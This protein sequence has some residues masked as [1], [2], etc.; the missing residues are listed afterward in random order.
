M[1]LPSESTAPLDGTTSGWVR[2]VPPRLAVFSIA[3]AALLACFHRPLLDLARFSFGH[4]LYSYILLIPPV[5]LYLMW[6]VRKERRMGGAPAARL[7]LLPL[8]LGL[9]LLVV[10]WAG[11]RAGRQFE[12]TD[13]LAV[14]T[15]S[16]WSFIAASCCIFLGA[17]T[18]RAIA[19]PL[20]FLLFASPLPASAYRAFESFLQHAS[21]TTAY[22]FFWAAFT[23]VWQDGLLLHLPGIGVEVAPECSGIRSTLVL[24]ITS[25]LAAHLFLRGPWRRAVLIC[26]VL[27]LALLRNGFRIF[28]IGE[29]CVHVGPQMINSPIHRHGGPL[30]FG[31]SLIPFL[32][33]LRRLRRSEVS[34]SPSLQ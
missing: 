22:G 8:A 11:R 15:L 16:L 1:E 27:P 28:I 24:F 17:R 21:A 9:G 19:F 14:M 34:A 10:Y 30:F 25:A 13:Y 18:L 20:V 23:P 31:L 3:V 33:L 26:A 4:D 32:W 6:L 5:S 2:S 29:L 12:P 7:A